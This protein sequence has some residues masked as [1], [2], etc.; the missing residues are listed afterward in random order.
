M[1][2]STAAAM[3][4][5]GLL[6]AGCGQPVT[7]TQSVG[8]P[9]DTRTETGYEEG[10]SPAA[11]DRAEAPRPETPEGAVIRPSA[12][13]AP[14]PA[15]NT[16]RNIGDGDA[17]ALTPGDQAETQADIEITRQI[18]RALTQHE[19]LSTT[20]KN[21]KIITAN[22]QVVLRGPVNSI[23]EQQQI[24][25]IAQEVDGVAVVDSELE[26]AME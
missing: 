6:L 9:G 1:K 14:E 20:A 5:V 15:D 22:G 23:K 19:D 10:A 2:F 12:P 26:L 16:G 13:V 24:V 7:D 25:Q 21:V 11:P 18:R 8:S 4:L 17:M 3:S